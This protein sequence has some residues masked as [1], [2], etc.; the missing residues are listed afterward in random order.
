M[1]FLCIYYTVLI[2]YYLKLSFLSLSPFIMYTTYLLIYLTA[3]CIFDLTL[4]RSQSVVEFSYCPVVVLLGR[5]MSCG[6]MTLVC[7]L[8]SLV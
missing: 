3:L 5:S 6:F 1:R 4:P 8:S 7:D 2:L